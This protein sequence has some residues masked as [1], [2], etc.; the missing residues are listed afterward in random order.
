ML[1]LA[2]PMDMRI[3]WPCAFAAHIC[4]GVGTSTP[5]SIPS[6]HLTVPSGRITGNAAISTL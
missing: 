6:A 5:V 3:V 2:P 1:A 4:A